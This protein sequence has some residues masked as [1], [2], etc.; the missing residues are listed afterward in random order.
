MHLDQ[1]LV[2]AQRQQIMQEVMHQ[3]VVSVQVLQIVQVMVQHMEL[4]VVSVRQLVLH[5]L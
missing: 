5:D 4:A 3:E 1:D 2:L